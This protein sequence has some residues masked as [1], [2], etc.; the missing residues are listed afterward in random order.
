[1][2]RSTPG[3]NPLGDFDVITGPPAPPAVLQ[4]PVE[5]VPAQPPRGGEAAAPAGDRPPVARQ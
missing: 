3:L 1:M 5:P 2:S 4:K